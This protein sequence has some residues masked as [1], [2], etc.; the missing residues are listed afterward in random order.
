[1]KKAEVLDELRTTRQELEEV[2]KALTPEQMQRPGVADDWSVK[3]TLAHL[4][5]YEREELELIRESGV[6][7]SSFW[8]APNEQRNELVREALRERSLEDVLAELRQVFTELVAA[9]GALSDD[10]LVTAG[11]FPGT[12]EERLPWQD[13]ALNSWMHEREHLDGIRSSLSGL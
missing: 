13:I 3:D 2:V 4:L 8:E 1:V 7:A 11:R 12:S 5:W 6:A 9:V 10:D